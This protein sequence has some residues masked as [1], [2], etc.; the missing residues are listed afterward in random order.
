MQSMNYINIVD[1]NYIRLPVFLLSNI[2]LLLLLQR[3]RFYQ[4]FVHM[5]IMER[6]HLDDIIK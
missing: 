5:S 2:E 4:G 3:I 6:C 1:M